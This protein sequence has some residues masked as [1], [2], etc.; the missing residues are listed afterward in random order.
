[1]Q[2]PPLNPDVADIPDARGRGKITGPAIHK[3]C[4]LI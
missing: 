2:K 3:P 1:M 4:A